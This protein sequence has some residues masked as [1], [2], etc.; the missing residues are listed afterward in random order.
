LISGRAPFFTGINAFREA[1]LALVLQQ[2]GTPALIF[3]PYF[4]MLI[5]YILVVNLLGL[6]PCAFTITSQLSLTAL[7]SGTVFGSALFV[8]LWLNGWRTIYMFLPAGITFL[9]L[10]GFLFGIELMSFFIRPCSLAIRLFANILAGHMLMYII[11]GLSLWLDVNRCPCDGILLP[12]GYFVLFV[13]I[14]SI[15]VLEFFVAVIQAYVF[16]ILGII[17]MSSAFRCGH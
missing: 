3:L 14:A 5:V 11:G 12:L 15:Y 2:G 10:Q 9:P 13:I 1:L 16:V 6:V 17:Y 7:L 4:M 8:I